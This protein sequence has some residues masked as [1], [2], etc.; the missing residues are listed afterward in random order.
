MLIVRSIIQPVFSWSQLSITETAFRSVLAS[1]RAFTPFLRV[2]HT[3]GTKTN[4]KQRARDVAYHRVQPSS[5]Y[6]LLI[7]LIPR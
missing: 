5:A 3:F 6:G 2:V 4:D 7:S 1:L